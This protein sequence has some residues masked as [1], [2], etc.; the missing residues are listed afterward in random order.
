MTPNGS[1]KPR[2]FPGVRVW[3]NKSGA[4]LLRQSFGLGGAALKEKLGASELRGLGD[5]AHEDRP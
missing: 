3:A 4:S 1:E 2:F 5:A